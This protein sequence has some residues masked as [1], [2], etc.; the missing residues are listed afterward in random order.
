MGGDSQFESLVQ[1]IN[2]SKPLKLG[3]LKI[4]TNLL[5]LAFL[6]VLKDNSFKSPT[7]LS[8]TVVLH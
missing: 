6:V 3:C 8:K 2:T 4:E 7:K 5:R 1:L